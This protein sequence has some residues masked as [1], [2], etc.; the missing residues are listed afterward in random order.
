MSR[1]NWKVKAFQKCYLLS[2]TR[3]DG[4]SQTD[5]CIRRVR[6]NEFSRIKTSFYTQLYMVDVMMCVMTLKFRHT[7]Y[8]LEMSLLSWKFS[9]ILNDTIFL[10]S[11]INGKLYTIIV[12]ARFCHQKHKYCWQKSTIALSQVFQP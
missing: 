4:F 7:S 6:K 5:S 9:T 1:S 11:S 10:K 3:P 2:L 8:W 12:T